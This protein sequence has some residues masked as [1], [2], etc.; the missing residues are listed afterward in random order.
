MGQPAA[1]TAAECAMAAGGAA[2]IARDAAATA[3]PA[4]PT[5]NP[6]N[7]AGHAADPWP[8]AA[9]LSRQHERSRR[10]PAR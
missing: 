10:R 3:S 4:E 6:R 9:T 2:R 7:S 5:I 1:R 8:A